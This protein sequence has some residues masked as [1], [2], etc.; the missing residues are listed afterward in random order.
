MDNANF[1]KN[2]FTDCCYFFC[3]VYKLQYVAFCE[4]EACK[5]LMVSLSKLL[6]ATFFLALS[7]FLM[8]CHKYKNTKRTLQV[9]DMVAKT[10]P[11]KNYS[12]NLAICSF[13]R[14]NLQC[15]MAKFFLSGKRKFQKS[16]IWLISFQRRNGNPGSHCSSFC[17]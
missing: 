16:Q 2:D 14:R 7:I 8:K 17:E 12:A 1:Y 4:N 5:R 15:K 10:V 6:F 9:H 11:Q 13:K 3:F